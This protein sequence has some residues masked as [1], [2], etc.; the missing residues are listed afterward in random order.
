[1]SQSFPLTH[2]GTGLLERLNGR[3]GPLHR[4]SR[5]EHLQVYVKAI[6]AHVG[7]LLNTRQGCSQS[8]PELGLADFNSHMGGADLISHIT[9]DIRRTLLVYEP[10]L[11]VE[12]LHYRASPD[13]PLELNFRLECRLRLDHWVEKIQIDLMVNQ[14]H[15]QVT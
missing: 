3:A 7:Q 10:R 2:V 11:E 12:G 13:V 8:S 6:K 9:A 1:M 4:Q 14:R 5:P 15:T